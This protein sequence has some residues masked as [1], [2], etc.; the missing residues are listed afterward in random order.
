MHAPEF[1]PRDLLVNMSKQNKHYPTSLAAERPAR[2]NRRHEGRRLPHCQS[3]KSNGRQCGS[4]AT[5]R[6]KALRQGHAPNLLL[7]V[8]LFS[9]PAHI[10]RGINLVAARLESQASR[11][12]NV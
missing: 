9:V 3:A 7:G 5:P 8:F 10:L 2:T 12:K 11:S 1:F 4:E 6:P